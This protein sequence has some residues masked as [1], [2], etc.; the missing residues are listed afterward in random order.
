MSRLHHQ[1]VAVAAVALAAVVT[2]AC[3]ASRADDARPAAPGASAGGEITVGISRPGSIEPGNTY[4]PAGALVVSTMCDTLVDIDPITGEL[5]PGLAEEWLI[6]DAGR[7]LNLRLREGI[8]FSNGKELDAGDVAFSLSR[9]ASESFASLDADLLRPIAGFAEMRGEVEDASP[10]ARRRL[11]GVVVTES[12][13]LQITLTEPNADFIRTLAH[14]TTAPV[15]EDT[16]RV[17]P[18]RFVRR[19]VCAGPYELAAEYRPDDPEIVLARNEH[20][21]P[22]GGAYTRGGAGYADRVRFVIHTDRAAQ[23][24]AFNAGTLD[25]AAVAPAD[26][27][28]A[29]TADGRLVESSSPFVDFIG[30]PT[31]TPPFTQRAV[32]MAFSQALD[33]RAVVAEAAPESR[34]PAADFL[35]PTLGRTQRDEACGAAAPLGGDVEAARA[36]LARAGVDLAEA[37][38]ELRYNDDF[39]N[40]KIVQAVAKQWAAAF[41]IVVTPVASNYE[42]FLADARPEGFER[43]FRTSWAAPSPSA[44]ASLVPL[45]STTAVGNTNMG[46]FSDRAFDTLITELARKSID[47]DDRAADYRRAEARLCKTMPMAPVA[48]GKLVHIV[49]PAVASAQNSFTDITT[50]EPLVRELYRK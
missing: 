4:E 6:G 29:R 38:L 12:R 47:D 50:G 35:P 18:E 48:T 5:V 23:L 7:Q 33:R 49:A 21:A 45:F 39:V 19:P 13:G 36:T 28:A 46:R 30:F 25:V 9:I 1:R 10:S 8:R 27:S 3:T 37:T 26:V 20:Y 41:G 34:E 16:A 14:P 44:D 40:A 17:S 43:L 2:A 24:A 42:A 11:G 32:R 22:G 31:A 15:H